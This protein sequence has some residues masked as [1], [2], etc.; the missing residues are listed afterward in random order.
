MLAAVLRV[1][2]W[3]DVPIAVTAAPTIVCAVPATRVTAPVEV[4]VLIIHQSKQPSIDKLGKVIPLSLKVPVGKVKD[5]AT[6]PLVTIISASNSAIVKVAVAAFVIGVGCFSNQ[7][8]F[9][10]YCI[11]L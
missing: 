9:P 10:I 6:V 2:H 5:I 3:L 8:L 11:S 1:R 4:P 7:P